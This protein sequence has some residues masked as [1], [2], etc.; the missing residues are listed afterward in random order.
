MEL[1]ACNLEGRGVPPPNT[2]AK[3]LLQEGAQGKS[4]CTPGGWNQYGCRLICKILKWN[5]DGCKSICKFR[6]QKRK[7][8]NRFPKP[9]FL[10]KK[11]IFFSR[12]HHTQDRICKSICNHHDSTSRFCKSVCTHIDSN[13]LAC[14]LISPGHPRGAIP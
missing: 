8:A 3:V 9:P 4:I 12:I 6:N 2:C 5:H 1:T 7:F 11:G 13:H 10:Y 14:K